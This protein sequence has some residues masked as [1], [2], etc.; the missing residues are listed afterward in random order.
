MSEIYILA[1]VPE[2]GKTTT[3]I[4]LEKKLKSEGKRVACLQMNKDRLDVYRYVSE[5]CYHYTVPFEATQ[6]KKAFEKWV[7]KGYDSYI[8]ELTYGFSPVGV[9]YISLFDHINE[10]ISSEYRNNWRQNAETRFQSDWDAHFPEIPHPPDLMSLWDIVHDRDIQQVFTKTQEADAPSVDRGRTLHNSEK[11]AVEQVRPEMGLPTGDKEVISV[12]VFPAEYCDIFSDLHWFG[13]DYAG[14]M[15]AFRKSKYDLAIIG[16]CGADRLK[17]RI[18]PDHNQVIC[19]Q[20]SVF[21]DLAYR[22]TSKPLRAGIRSIYETI[23]TKKPGTALTS[24]G[25]PFSG[26]NNPYWVYRLY[27]KPEVVWKADN[28]LFC[29]GWVLPQYLIRDGYLE[30]R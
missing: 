30:V 9:P 19:Y 12:G 29:N 20:P 18:H 10:V 28:T 21:L 7:P 3:A 13:M 6:T 16:G 1:S 23:K 14:F 15:D 25:E 26:Y 17:L 11:L 27:D 5:G 4:L 22:K 24:E 8:L 2:Q